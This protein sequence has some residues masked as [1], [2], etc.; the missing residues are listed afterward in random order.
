MN[1]RQK[2]LQLSNIRSEEESQTESPVARQRKALQ[3]FA[4]S[5]SASQNSKQG[6]SPSLTIKRDR[7]SRLSINM[8]DQSEQAKASDLPMIDP[9][10]IKQTS[11]NSREL[12][13]PK[14]LKQRLSAL[15]ILE[16]AR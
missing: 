7:V 8:Q 15:G 16:E 4:A 10:K 3:E 11:P 2:K 5:M 9:N 6:N 12:Q 14:A 13:S 1:E